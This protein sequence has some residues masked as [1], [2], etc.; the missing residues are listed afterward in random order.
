[1]AT[2]ARIPV[3]SVCHL[4]LFLVSDGDEYKVL[5]QATVVRQEAHA[6]ALRFLDLRGPDSLDNLETLIRFHTESPG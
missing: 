2:D 1:M 6:L 3:G 4:V 5:A